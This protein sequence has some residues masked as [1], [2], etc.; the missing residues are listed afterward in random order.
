MPDFKARWKYPYSSTYGFGYDGSNDDYMVV[1]IHCVY[2]GPGA[3][4]KSEA[5]VYSLKADSWRKIENLK[6]G[7]PYPFELGKFVSGKL[8]CKVM[9]RS[10]SRYWRKIV[11]LDLLSLTYGEVEEAEYSEGSTFSRLY[12]L[13]GCLAAACHYRNTQSDI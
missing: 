1:G 12:V 2:G 8:H 9:Y 3:P 10:G 13:G 11:S 7:A 4:H 5:L 6:G